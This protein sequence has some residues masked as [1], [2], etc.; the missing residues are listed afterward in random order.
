MHLRSHFRQLDVA[1]DVLLREMEAFQLLV[2]LSWLTLILCTSSATTL[3]DADSLRAIRDAWKLNLPS[4]Q[5]DDPCMGWEHVRCDTDG[6]VTYLNLSNLGIAGDIP[7]EI[8]NLDRLTNLDLGN[9][10]SSILPYNSVSGGLSAFESLTSLLHLNLSFNSL[11]LD[12]FPSSIF[13]LTNLVSLRLDNNHILGPLPKELAGLKN[14]VYLYLGNNSLRGPI[15]VEYG[16]MV[17]L[18]E[19]SIWNNYLNSK[20]PS[21]L[22]NLQNLRYLNL[23]DCGL[24][25]GLPQE[26]GRL[27]K[28]EGIF[29]NANKLTGEVP[30]AWSNL[31]E[32]QNL[33]L[34]N[35]YLTKSIPRWIFT[36]P[37]LR[38]L[39][40]GYNLFY[41][42]LSIKNIN[43]S[44]VYLDCNFLSGPAPELSSTV[45]FGGNCFAGA[46]VNDKI[47]CY[48][49]YYDCD[50]FFHGVSNGTCPN[51]PAG[52]FLYNVSTC[53]CMINSSKGGSSSRNTLKVIGY[54][55]AAIGFTLFMISALWMRSGVFNSK[56]AKDL[57]EV[58]EGVQR[59]MYKDISKT[60]NNFDSNHEIGHGGFGKVYIGTVAGRTVAI[61]RA[62]ASS[63]QSVSGFR[64]EV[65]LLSRLHHRNLVRLLGFCEEN[66]TQPHP[67]RMF[68][69]R[70]MMI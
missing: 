25:G 43:I 40:L 70:C 50:L 22:G 9:P 32:L 55:A 18:Q 63:I 47:K 8:R 15:P 44:Y 11:Q 14:L 19:L 3:S 61:K 65:V 59:F 23:H 60:T 42:G 17:N 48:Q 16:A 41:G 6:R 57:W 30:G 26:L 33:Y 20:I 12:V 68:L 4:W 49:S 5:G 39:S 64:N 45:F 1:I 69:L 10:R 54:V 51:C 36:L 35:N 34:K 56:S 7:N 67:T 27:K 46:N 62:H 37:N 58:P 52:Q 31:T 28:I 13:N 66:K 29:L 21:E 38:N 24:Y 53:V 2:V